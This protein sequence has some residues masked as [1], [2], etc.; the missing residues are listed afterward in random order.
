M[1][2]EELI[3]QAHEFLDID[4][5]LKGKEQSLM[6]AEKARLEELTADKEPKPKTE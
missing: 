2:D 1:N 6:Y 4:F 3:K 5:L